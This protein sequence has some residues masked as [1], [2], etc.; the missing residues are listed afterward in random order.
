MSAH[1]TSP[2]IIF[3]G[4]FGSGKTEVALNYARAISGTSLPGTAP[5]STP[6]DG[7]VV[8]IDLDIVTPYFRSRETA[9]RM[10][11]LGIE[12]VA[13]S[14][15]GQHLDTPAITPQLLGAIERPDRR[16]VL[17]VG[18]DRQGARALGQFSAA[19]SRRGYIMHFV[20]NPFRPFTATVEGLRS[21]VA[22]IEQSARLK[23]TSL[24]SNPNL[25]HETTREQAV[26]GHAAVEAFAAE[27]DLPIAFVCLAER[28]AEELGPMFEQ[29]V[30]ALARYFAQPW[31]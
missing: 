15:I 5:G 10:G 24:V 11:A 25:M 16:V 18:G 2:A 26:A 27:V 13:P 22:E 21:S 23:V 8:V 3:T 4:R 14:I 30:L 6:G 31:E 28:W 17:D 20:V 1:G 19:L 12:V 29:P 7:S 9:E